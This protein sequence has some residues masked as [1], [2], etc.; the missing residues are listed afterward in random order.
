MAK[1]GL[2]FNWYGGRPRAL[3]HD[4]IDEID[5]KLMETANI[6]ASLLKALIKEEHYKTYLRKYLDMEINKTPEYKEISA[7][8]MKRYITMFI[9]QAGVPRHLIN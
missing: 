2:S 6:T 7:R 8:S 5:S 1:K 3:D 9:E 4:S